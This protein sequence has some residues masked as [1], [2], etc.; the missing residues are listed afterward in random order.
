[1]HERFVSTPYTGIHLLALPLYVATAEDAARFEGDERA[2]FEESFDRLTRQNLTSD[3]F[4]HALVSEDERVSAISKK[5]KT[6]RNP[7]QRGKKRGEGK[8][9]I[10]RPHTPPPARCRIHRPA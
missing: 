7:V 8:P 1:M 5:T 6:P 3:S 2:F 9:E 10:G 4:V